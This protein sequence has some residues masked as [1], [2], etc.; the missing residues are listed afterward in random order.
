MIR[1]AIAIEEGKTLPPCPVEMKAVK[2]N[3]LI[4]DFLR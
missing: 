3:F 4:A 1:K 2:H